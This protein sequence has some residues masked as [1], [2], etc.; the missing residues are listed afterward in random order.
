MKYAQFRFNS[1]EPMS[2]LVMTSGH[3]LLYFTGAMT[4]GLVSSYDDAVT[5]IVTMSS[6]PFAKLGPMFAAKMQ[7]RSIVFCIFIPII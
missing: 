5:L 3:N 1:H 2:S 4:G 7:E 6:S